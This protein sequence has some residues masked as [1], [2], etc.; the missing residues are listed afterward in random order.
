MRALLAALTLAAFNPEEAPLLK[1]TQLGGVVASVRAEPGNR[2]VG[3]PIACTIL[4]T[5]P[6]APS[7]AISP[8]EVLGEFDVLSVSNPRASETSE[9]GVL[10]DIVISTLASGRVTPADLEVRWVHDGSELS[11]KVG[12]PA[13]SVMSLVGETADPAKFRDIAGVIDIPSPLAWLPWAAG[14]LALALAG[15]AAWMLLRARPTAPV[16]AD[17]W[18]LAQLAGLDARGLPAKREFGRYYDDLSGIVRRYVSLRYAIPAEQQTTREFLDAAKSRPEFPDQETDRLH[19][20][21]RLA[22]LV[23]FAAAEPTCDECDSHLAEARAFVE[24]TR[25]HE[26]PT[27]GRST[28]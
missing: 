18:A 4:F 6:D 21:L 12:F 10:V 15:A 19:A 23:K 26:Q 17:A 2:E 14:G 9:R 16:S 24:S 20:L 22:D 5:G 8:V 13:F 27:A 3:V 1:E 11:G 25:V 28:P 7:V